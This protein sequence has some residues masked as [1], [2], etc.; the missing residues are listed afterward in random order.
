MQR[1]LG[2]A[3]ASVV[4]ATVAAPAAVAQGWQ[5]PYTQGPPVEY[6]DQ[7]LR[8]RDSTRH[9]EFRIRAFLQPEARL[10]VGDGEDLYRSEFGVRR[11]RLWIQGHIGKH[12][13]FRLQPEFAGTVEVLDAF[14]DLSASR[15]LWLRLGRL[16]TPFGWE[17]SR[18]ITEHLLPERSVAATNLTSN[19]DNGVQA[20]GTV[21]RNRLEYTVGV[22]NGAVDRQSASA[23]PNDAKDFAW[24][25]IAY[26]WIHP[27]RGVTQGLLVG[28]NG[29]SGTEN[30]S[31]ASAQL[32][33]Y[34]TTAG[35]T[36]FGY[37]P[38]F[39]ADG[40]RTRLNVFGSL[41]AGAVGVEGEW[42]QSRARVGGSGAPADLTHQGWTAS[43]AVVLSGEPM[44][45]IGITP[46]ERFN[47]EAGQWGA[48]Q[49]AGRVS[50]L[51]LDDATF[52]TYADPAA[53]ARSAT[54]WQVGV[55]WYAARQTKAQVVFSST[56]FDGGSAV[57]D[58]PPE[59][60]VWLRLQFAM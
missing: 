56:S 7:G 35:V 28:V 49:L 47:P 22:F 32:P 16:R 20:S 46:R 36:F 3:I 11:A 21:L 12:L 29:M 25:L 40:Q 6:G 60:L 17:R 23:D 30:G 43:A 18:P 34:V 54:E 19:R 38:G 27:N 53:S 44:N 10:A 5:G 9:N 37:R 50:R 57:G 55:N 1:S 48:F 4:L 15:A 13:V 8:L 42:L 59:Q 41:T 45:F 31:A 51:L 52:P 39:Y 33:T 24:R 26:P 58:R 14:V 2:W